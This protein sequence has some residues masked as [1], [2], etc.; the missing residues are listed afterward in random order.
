MGCSPTNNYAT[1]TVISFFDEEDSDTP[2]KHGWAALHVVCGAALD[3]AR[4]A[5]DVAQV[6][7][8]ERAYPDG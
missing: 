1:G 8:E 3:L 5:V 4:I 6:A 7:I 2:V